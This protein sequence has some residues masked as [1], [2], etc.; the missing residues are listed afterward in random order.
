MCSKLK[1]LYFLVLLNLMFFITSDGRSI[2]R[3]GGKANGP[4]VPKEAPKSL[5]AAKSPGFYQGGTQKENPLAL[6][7]DARNLRGG[8]SRG[9]QPAKAWEAASPAKK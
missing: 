4:Q 9:Q 3:R 6:L 7:S 8:A 5:P 2:G 1:E